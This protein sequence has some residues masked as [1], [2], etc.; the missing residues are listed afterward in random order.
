VEDVA[1]EPEAIA[2][3]RRALGAQLTTFRLAAE[4]TQGQLAK[5]AFCDRTTLVHIEKGR[6]RADERFWRIVDDA[7]QAEGV[8]LAAFLE[9]EAAKAEH[10]QRERE[11]RLSAVRARVAVLQ[12]RAEDSNTRAE[13]PALDHLRQAVL[14]HAAP[15]TDTAD[16]SV[17]NVAHTE[18]SIMQVHR[19]YQLADYDAS[20]RLLALVLQR[21]TATIPPSMTAAT[22]LAATKL[23]TKLGDAGLAWVSADRCLRFAID[24]QRPSLIGI[25][26]Y[27]VACA[28]LA[29]QH[30]AVA[31]QTAT[32]AAE[33]LASVAIK[34][35]IRR[36]EALSVQGALV[37]LLAVI[38][39]RRDDGHV[40]KRHLLEASHLAEQLG[41]NDNRLWT[42]FGPTNVAIHELSVQVALGDARRAFQFG[43]TL[44]TDALPPVLRGRRSQVHL[45]L[46]WAA[47]QQGDDS[48]AVLHLLEAE[49]VASQA[50]SRNA[51]ARSLLTTLLARERKSATPGLRALASRAGMMQ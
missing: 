33:Q 23:A 42:A 26:H 30:V 29:A 1:R 18:A 17:A 40:A 2:E 51:T 28:L 27:Q 5:L 12:G 41:R 31:E 45:E 35:R 3:L 21:G 24:A 20:S 16:S 37:L 48:L 34:P 14:G 11:Q 13:V 15:S 22:Y 50:V 7:C 10:E 47:V 9:L 6:G 43:E 19:L 8:L 49:R 4:L 25:A 32:I 46:A 38:A 36:D 44:D 39:A